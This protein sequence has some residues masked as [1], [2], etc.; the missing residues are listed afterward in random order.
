MHDEL[1]FDAWTPLSFKRVMGDRHQGGRSWVAPTWVGH[2]A[3]RLMAYKV[4][5]AYRDNS[6]RY[7]LA[8]TDLDKR[9]SHR[10]YG[11]ADLIVE[12]ILSA[13]LGDEQAIVAEGAEDFDPDDPETEGDRE[14][15]EL[16]EWVREWAD[17][18]RFALKLIESENNSV[19]LGD[20]LY[21]LG[22]SPEKRRVRLRVWDPGFYFPVLDDGNEDDFPETM[23]VAWELEDPDD[24]SKFLV[25]R[26]TWRLVN[27]AGE[28]DARAYN[29]PWNDEPTTVTCLMSD[30]T[31]RSDRL[32]QTVEDFT[33]GVAT[34]ATYIDP[35]TG[36]ER[37]WRDIDLGVDFIPVIH[38][39]NTVSL[40]NH[41]G[42]SSLT[43]VLQILD[44]L[45]NSDTDLQAASGTT[46]TPPIALK[47]R[48]G[49]DQSPTYRPGEVW[50]LGDEG[51]LDVLDTSK[52][53]DALIKY[54]EFLLKR[55]SVN[56]RVPE[57][58]QGRVELTGNLAGITVA[59]TFGPLKSMIGKMRLVRGEKYPLLFRMAHRMSVAY[60]VKDVPQVFDRR[61]ELQLGSFL[62][63]DDRDLIERVKALLEAKAISPE[64]AIAMLVEGGIPI[65]DAAEE[66]QR[67]QSRDFEGANT[68]FDATGDDQAV[69]DYLGLEGPGPTGAP[70][71]P[72]V[73]Q[74]PPAPPSPPVLPPEI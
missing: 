45:A 23:H 26:V 10:E 22:W 63:S 51:G 3:R 47:G 9:D 33:E 66:V 5:Q 52:S 31:W 50:E 24:P 29:H 1:V 25:R 36:E 7:F 6:A 16:Q 8:T 53:L 58:I 15:F 62:P 70:P 61:V 48:L 27:R 65:D 73:I 38:V 2:H 60:G 19:G 13:L 46:G 34:Y 40:L 41:Y 54:I 59:L 11:D 55:L 74:P 57:A 69:R 12:L 18:E 49:K 14:A 68:L 32:K 64:T 39:P 67:I 28:V 42:K 4:L 30:A 20:G 72:P 43:T 21:S 17:D 37:P 71:A 35:D 44:D 56:S